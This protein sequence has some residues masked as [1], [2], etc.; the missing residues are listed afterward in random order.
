MLVLVI[1]LLISLRIM[2]VVSIVI[3]GVWNVR[4]RI[5]RFVLFVL[6]GIS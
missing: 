4:W 1:V 6:V 5:L 3:P 2:V